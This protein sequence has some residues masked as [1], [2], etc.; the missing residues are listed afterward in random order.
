MEEI[1]N[2]FDA[3]A[4][5][6][7]GTVMDHGGLVGFRIPEYQ[8]EYNWSEGNIT[9]LF[10]DCLS[11]LHRL[12]E[13]SN[14]NPFT[15]LG[16]IIL[17]NE[18]LKREKFRGTS[19]AI[20]DGQQRL[21]TLT[22]FSCALHENLQ[23]SIKSLETMNIG[24][25]VKRWIKCE[26]KNSLECLFKC[27]VGIQ[28]LEGNKEYYFPRIIQQ[29]DKRGDSF[30]TSEYRSAVGAFLF[31]FARY[32]RKDADEFQVS[33]FDHGRSKP[34]LLTNYE[35]VK[36]CLEKLNDT[37]WYEDQECEQVPIKWFDRS[38]CRKLLDRLGSTIKDEKDQNRAIN[39]LLRCEA[40]HDLV[41]TLFFAAYFCRNIVL[42]RVTTDEESVAFDIFD[43]LN[44]TGEPLTALE[45]LKP[46]VIEFEDSN[47]GFSGTESEDA[48]KRLQKYVDE[49]YEDATKK[50]KETKELLVSF[51]LHMTGEKLPEHLQSQRN[52]LRKQYGKARNKSQK[53]AQRFV[54]LLA[55][56]AEF[57][58]YYWTKQGIEEIGRFHSGENLGQVQLLSSF[59][60]DTGTKLV[61]P[62]LMRYWNIY[63]KRD[64]DGDFLEVL[65]AVTAFL[66]LRRAAS[67]GTANIDR[68]F[69]AI[70]APKNNSRKGFGLCAG[71][72]SENQELSIDELWSAFKSLLAKSEFKITRKDEWI[73]QVIAQPL[74]RPAKKIVRFLL[75]AAAD[76]SKP[77]SQAPGCWE[78]E[79]IRI[80]SHENKFLTYETWNSELYETVEHIAPAARQRSG[81]DSD[82]YEDTILRDSLGNL[83]LLPRKENSAI[84]SN[85]WKQKRA[86]YL[87][88][89]E[90]T[91]EQQQIKIKEAAKLDL[92]FSDYTTK[93]LQ[94]GERLSLLS[95][96]RDVESWDRYTIEARARNTAELTWDKLWPWLS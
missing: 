14:A 33:K 75:L 39:D 10:T 77:S 5:S 66:V 26:I 56:M 59:I 27:S 45:T 86:F 69:R 12:A 95:P 79:G 83:S 96:L 40:A 34:K 80:S 6:L 46:Q 20:V 16:T 2:L 44:T 90:E 74:Y 88:V 52:F 38:G 60:R 36:K 73:K 65:K 49:E 71:V 8:R 58:W 29:Y 81:W 31:A 24:S 17:V 4:V 55:D 9:R 11:G 42:T 85:S 15:F 19:L 21:I 67:G 28:A 48:F 61:L 37:K 76:Q 84:G 54:S 1:E 30:R 47:R 91:R 22:L 82:I 62:I 25:I 57:R 87:A 43:A 93:L 18:K 89:T 32:A 70:M 63:L 68:D 50:Q 53:K 23:A 35:L 51:A 13:G 72:D 64:G 78:K 92:K 3:K 41:R 94:K 7:H